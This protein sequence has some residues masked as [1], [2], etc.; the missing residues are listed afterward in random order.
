MQEGD[1]V[2]QEL[3]RPVAPRTTK[4]EQPPSDGIE[5][6]ALPR[7]GRTTDG[8]TQ[9]LQGVAIV[10]GDAGGRVQ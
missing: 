9:V 3:R 7:K 4:L 5:R 6:Q 8:T 10:G 1:G 2:K